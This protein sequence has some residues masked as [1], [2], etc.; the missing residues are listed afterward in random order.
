MFGLAAAFLVWLPLDPGERAWAP[1]VTALFFAILEAAVAHRQWRVA[2]IAGDGR[3]R[4][5]WRLLASAS[6]LRAAY[7]TGW[8]TLTMRGTPLAEPLWL[9]GLSVAQLVALLAGLLR[10]PIIPWAPGDRL[11]LRLDSATVVVGSGL[12]VWFFAVGPIVRNPE[13]MSSSVIDAVYSVIDIATV[14]IASL[15]FSARGRG[16]RATRCPC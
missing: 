8:M 13:T 4:S 12:L 15:S 1:G 3:E 7:C 16:S 9:I 11:P 10:F 14:V 2:R 6:L 5:A